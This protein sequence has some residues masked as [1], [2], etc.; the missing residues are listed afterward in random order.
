ME[1]VTRKGS[2]ANVNPVM[3]YNKIFMAGNIEASKTVLNLTFNLSTPADLVN[4]V[5]FSNE[6]I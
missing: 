1:A 6:I 2:I 3:Y 4:R 5:N